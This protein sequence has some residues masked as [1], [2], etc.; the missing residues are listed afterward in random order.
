MSRSA[1]VAPTRWPATLS[2][3]DP[4]LLLLRASLLALLINSNDDVPV[5]IAVAAVS[6]VALP[7]P[8]L[9]RLPLFWLALFVGVGARQLA[10]WH[11]IDDHIIVTTYWCG[12]IALGL[13]AS[14]Q[15]RSLAASARFLVGTLFAFAAG[16]KL[17]SGQFADGTFF[18][19]TLLFDD[20]FATVARLIGDTSPS[21]LRANVEA[22]QSLDAAGRAGDISLQE[23]PGN[24]LLA[25]V[26]TGWGILIESAVAAAFLLPLRERWGWV[27]HALLIAFAATTYLIVPIGGFGT[28]LLVLG[29][30]QATNGALRAGYYLG[31]TALIVWAGLWPLAFM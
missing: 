28:L 26:F 22:L 1:P 20:R 31:G 24:Q 18:R 10:T 6:V 29:A 23:G 11:A 27:R 3:A 7:R 17:L 4:L 14:D 9:L 5:L 30:A 13:G 8:G 25:D 21:M 2:S 15:R 16:W 19:Y 12:A